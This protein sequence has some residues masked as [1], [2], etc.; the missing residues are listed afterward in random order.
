MPAPT[1]VPVGERCGWVG[2]ASASGAQVAL[3]EPRCQQLWLDRVIVPCG[4]TGC[5]LA[6]ADLIPVRLR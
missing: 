5:L 3:R 4:P 2:Q 6:L 1:W